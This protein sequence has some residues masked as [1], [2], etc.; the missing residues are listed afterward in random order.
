M[1]KPDPVTEDLKA[2]IAKHGLGKIPG[3]EPDPSQPSLLDQARELGSGVATDDEKDFFDKLIQT[4]TIRENMRLKAGVEALAD[5][6]QEF[7][8]HLNL[9]PMLARLVK[10]CTP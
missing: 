8:P 1:S 5:Y 2:L 7:A 6:Y 10:D 4:V 3:T 9:P